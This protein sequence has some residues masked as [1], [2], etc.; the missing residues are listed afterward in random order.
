MA[1][2]DT[3]NSCK[4]VGYDEFNPVSWPSQCAPNKSD[5]IEL[6][7]GICGAEN[8]PYPEQFWAC[9]DISIY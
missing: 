9:S 2:K 4:H 6:D 1:Q 8:Y 5:W 3:G 7:R